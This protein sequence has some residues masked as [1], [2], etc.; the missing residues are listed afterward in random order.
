MQGEQVECVSVSL[1][2]ETGDPNYETGILKMR[3]VRG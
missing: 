1:K 3:P 2:D